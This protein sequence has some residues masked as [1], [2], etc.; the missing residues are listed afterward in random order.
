[1]TRLPLSFWV[2]RLRN[3]LAAVQEVLAKDKARLLF[4]KT[5]RRHRTRTRRIVSS[6]GLR[7]ALQLADA[8]RS[9]MSHTFCRNAGWFTASIRNE[10]EFPV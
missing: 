2:L 3:D 6:R 5:V 9:H 4:S 10:A 8:V 1:M 7:S